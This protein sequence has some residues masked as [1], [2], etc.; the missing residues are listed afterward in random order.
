MFTPLRSLTEEQYLSDIGRKQV[1]VCW[2]GDVAL[3]VTHQRTSA[4]CA[5]APSH[6]LYSAWLTTCFACG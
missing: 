1:C 2:A 3:L 6:V 4:S 5:L